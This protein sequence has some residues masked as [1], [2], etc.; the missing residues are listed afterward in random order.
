M[1]S[2]ISTPETEA[3]PSSFMTRAANVFSSP[4]TLFEEVK[5]FPTRNSSWIIPLLITGVFTMFLTFGIFSNPV[6]VQQIRETQA[7][8]MDKAVEEG[9]MTREQADKA[10]EFMGSD[11]LFMMAFGVVSA[12]AIAAISFFVVPLM[13]WLAVKA[14]FSYQGGYGKMLEVFGLSSLIGA[15]GILASLILITVFDSLHATPGGGLLL[16]DS[17]DRENIAHN[18]LSSVNV[19]TLWQ[20]AVVGIGMGKISEKPMEA[21]MGLAFALWVV[22]AVLA[23]TL[24]WGGR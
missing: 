15:L 20:V 9:K 19:F 8:Q 1:D 5:A 21:G 16:L 23:S 13:L 14:A 6:L 12:A 2:E 11:S 18:F 22:W 24:G 10:A 17:F 7:T 4:G 3:S